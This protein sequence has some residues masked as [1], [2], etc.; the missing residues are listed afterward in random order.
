MPRTSDTRQ[1]KPP[2]EQTHAIGLRAIAIY[3]AAKSIGL[4]LVAAAA[5][6]LDRAQN[7]EQ[8]VHWLEN[9]SL[10][11]S[12]ELRWRLVDMLTAMGPQ[13]FVAVGLVALAY[14][15]L[16]AVEGVGLWL[17]KRWAQWFTVIATGLLV[18][19]EFYEVMHRF[20]GTRLA[21]LLLNIAVVVY[22]LRTVLG[23]RAAEHEAH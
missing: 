22:L 9:L 1:L 7:F 10:A 12:S 17:R 5:F 15:A 6:R 19:L 20:S 11:D 4:L 23:S 14:A 3:K 18:P 16:F 2:T 13:K 8:L 21:V